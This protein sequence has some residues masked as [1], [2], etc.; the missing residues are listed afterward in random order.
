MYNNT[1]QD[2]NAYYIVVDV[3]FVRRNYFDRGGGCT[4]EARVPP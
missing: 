1:R 4:A 2:Y 3:R